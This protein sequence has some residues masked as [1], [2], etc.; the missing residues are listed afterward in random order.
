M[1]I[2]GDAL[3]L[4]AGC[5][6]TL[7]AEVPAG[8]HSTRCAICKSRRDVVLRDANAPAEG[9]DCIARPVAARRLMPPSTCR[10]GVKLG[11]AVDVNLAESSHVATSR[12]AL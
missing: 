9:A 12:W 5:M 7:T 10:Q 4:Q 1:T 11:A 3:A 2:G 6:P 8:Q